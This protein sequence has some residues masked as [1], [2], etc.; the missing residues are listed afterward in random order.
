MNIN[1]PIPQLASWRTTASG[2]VGILAGLSALCYALGAIFHS[3]ATGAFGDLQGELPGLLVA[4]GAVA[5]GVGNIFAK[6]AQV[7]GGSISA[8]TGAKGPAVSLVDVEKV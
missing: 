7:T 8:V 5:N 6:D 1:I 4:G 3:L 2:I